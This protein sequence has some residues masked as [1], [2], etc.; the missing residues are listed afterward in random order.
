MPVI[1]VTNLKAALAPRARLLG[2]DVGS[3]NVN[4]YVDSTIIEGLKKDGYFVEMAKAF[5]VK[6]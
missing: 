4:D 1:D 5:P 3:K 6:Q 2:L